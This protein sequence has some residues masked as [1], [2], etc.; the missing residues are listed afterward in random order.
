MR[1]QKP[2]ESVWIIAGQDRTIRIRGAAI[3][4]MA[5]LFALGCLGFGLLNPIRHGLAIA[6]VAAKAHE[7]AIHF[8][9][10]DLV[11]ADHDFALVGTNDDRLRTLTG[12]QGGQGQRRRQE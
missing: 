4:Y 5:T 7:D 2:R 10:E 8:D 3:I 9:V 1:H 11:G 6:L 12:D